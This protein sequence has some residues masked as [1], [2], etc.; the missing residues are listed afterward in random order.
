[1]RGTIGSEVR[2]LDDAGLS[3][4]LRSIGYACFVEHF[5]TLTDESLSLA[6]AVDRLATVSTWTEAGRRMRVSNARRIGRA[7]RLDDALRLVAAAGRIEPRIA[8]AA[9]R[10][11][12]E[13]CS[14]RP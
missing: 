12:A 6:S 10:R 1:M 14:D 8:E 13:R 11:L 3:R 2:R 5:E 4:A 9:R 7:G